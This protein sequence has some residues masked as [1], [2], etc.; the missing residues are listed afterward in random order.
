MKTIRIGLSLFALILAPTL[1]AQ[2]VVPISKAEVLKTVADQNLAI[3]ISEQEFQSAQAAYRQTNAVLFP[4]IEVSH[5]GITTT[6]PLMAFGSKLNQEIIT[7]QDFN[8]ALLND[9]SRISNYAT[10]LDVKQPIVNL[11]GIYQ[12]KAAKVKMQAV[13]LQS[14]R[15]QEQMAFEVEK[16]YMQLQLAYKARTVLDK[17][18]EAARA[19]KKLADDN[20]KEGYLHEADVLAVEVRILDIQNQLQSAQSNIENSSNYLSFLMGEK[21]GVILMPT[22]S[23]VAASVI[24][25]SSKEV[26]RNRS[27]IKAMQLASEAFEISHRANK[28][29]FLP[30]LNAFGSYQLYDEDVFQTDASGYVVGAQLSW[31]ILDGAR[32]IGKA[33]KSNAEAQRSQL[34]YE[35]YVS[36]NNLEMNKA[37]RMLL[38]AK[39]KLELSKLALQQSGES[40]RIRTD[41]FEQGLEK[42]ADLLTAE[43]QYAEKELAYYQ[44]VYELNFAL[45]YIDFL[46]KE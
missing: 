28:M 23:L 16:A 9:P 39:N 29:A 11:D 30:R 18:L 32:R 7:Q 2:E 6:N 45:A 19:N 37:K 34:Q 12:R 33:Q 40:L 17:A 25:E 14:I 27:D 26:S 21:E 43:T 1:W 24:P 38:D 4:K 3:K 22:D 31:T 15:T 10:S 13:E 41:R 46:T 20:F 35:Q 5:M 42:T 8:P 36:Q 44:T